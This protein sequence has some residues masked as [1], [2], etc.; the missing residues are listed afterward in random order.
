M[1]GLVYSLKP[2]KPKGKRI[3]MHR[4]NLKRYVQRK[5]LGNKATEV[6][7]IPIVQPIAPIAIISPTTTNPKEHL[8]PNAV[9]VVVQVP[10]QNRITPIVP[11][12]QT[13]RGRGRPP[14]SITVINNNLKQRTTN[15]NSNK[16][17]LPRK[18]PPRT[19][20]KNKNYK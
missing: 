20:N 3:T 2:I 8:I 5:Q 4:N 15:Q 9:A 7:S 19:V 17:V 18:N 1:D 6:D 11:V 14:K 13:K 12:Q 16:P 10:V